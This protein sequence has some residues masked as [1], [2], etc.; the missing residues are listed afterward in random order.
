ML[1][2]Q[3]C[4]Q[5]FRFGPAFCSVASHDSW[6]PGVRSRVN[7]GRK[8]LS[9]AL[10]IGG[11]LLVLELVT[12]VSRPLGWAVAGITLVVVLALLAQTRK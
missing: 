1:C 2:N 10:T 3:P 4:A 7:I 8:W 5:R 11:T 9:A 12:L 6:N